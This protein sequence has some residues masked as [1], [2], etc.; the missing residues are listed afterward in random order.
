MNS[1]KTLIA[2]L[3]LA[4]V[5]AGAYAAPSDHHDHRS[6]SHETVQHQDA[7]QVRH[8]RRM[9]RAGYWSGRHEHYRHV[10]WERHHPMYRWGY[11]HEWRR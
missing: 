7:R 11:H 5:T 3:A 2:A 4:G 1:L 9:F 6:F 8:D 10:R